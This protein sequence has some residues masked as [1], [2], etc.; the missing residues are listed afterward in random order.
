MATNNA[1]VV[2]GLG[3]IGRALIDHLTQ[4]PD[5]D[6]V[7]LSRRAPDFETTA[8][9]VSVDLSDRDDAHAKLAALDQTTHVFY[10]AYQAMP[11]Y[12]D[13]VAPNVTL[14]ANAVDALV[15]AAPGLQHVNL[16]EGGK[17]YGC[18][19]GPFRT[20]A[21]EDDPRHMPPNFYYDQQDWL[22]AAA[23]QHG[24]TWS[25]LRP[26]AVCG[27][28]VGNPMNLMMAIAVY[29]AICAEL[30][31]PFAFPGKPGA[32][33]AVYEVTDARILAQ[34]AQWAATTPS[35]AGE[36]F[37]ITNGD[38]FRWCN[39]WPKLAESFGLATAEPRHLSLTRFMADKAPV[40]ERIVAKHNLRPYPFEDVVSW[41]FAD[42][43]FAT[44]WDIARS[45]LK[46]RR[47][48]FEAFIETDRMFS[49]LF[50]DL[51]RQRIIPTLTGAPR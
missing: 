27:F 51:Q 31:V 18:H 41:G 45:T 35:S 23:D 19:L 38:V 2:G 49:E 28:A 42:A 30:D 34:A 29:A 12:A 22:E 40:W 5:W 7:A 10:A 36:A 16:M 4:Q 3:V 48:G 26:E 43:I 11:T 39:L 46:A 44:E 9:F 32:W 1:V 47:H 13:E 17:W 50:D 20:P 8:R 14:L 37:N 15:A 21:V 6:V 33:T 24:F 25:A